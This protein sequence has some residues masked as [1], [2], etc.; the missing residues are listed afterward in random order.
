MDT[1]GLSEGGSGWLRFCH[2]CCW[3]LMKGCVCVEWRQWHQW[4]E[5]H[6]PEKMDHRSGYFWWQH[7]ESRGF[8]R[9]FL[10]L[11]LCSNLHHRVQLKYAACERHMMTLVCDITR[12]QKDDSRHM[13]VEMLLQCRRRAV[14]LFPV[15]RWK[16]SV[17]SSVHLPL[18]LLFTRPPGGSVK[19]H[20]IELVHHTTSEHKP[21]TMES[22]C[23]R[24][25]FQYGRRAEQTLV[26]DQSADGWQV[27]VS[28][29]HLIES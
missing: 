5:C 12:Q 9:T 15:M 23:G 3:L 29:L 4:F 17:N 6:Q 14:R 21:E 22:L 26:S 28:K 8:F 24:E 10:M 27:R 2:V 16:V 13:S 7:I 11:I 25:T 1:A 20:L 19:S 18:K